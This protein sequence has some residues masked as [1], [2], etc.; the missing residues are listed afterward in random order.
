MTKSLQILF[1]RHG[2]HQQDSS[3]VFHSM[4][5]SGLGIL[6]ASKCLNISVKVKWVGKVEER[7]KFPITDNN[8]LWRTVSAFNPDLTGQICRRRS[9]SSLIMGKMAG[10]GLI[11]GSNRDNFI[12]GLS[13]SGEHL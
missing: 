8:R 3:L 7:G 12:E 13:W 6:H 5:R 1:W 10:Q 11:L 4:E 9:P 2:I